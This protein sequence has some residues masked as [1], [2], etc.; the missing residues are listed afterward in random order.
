MTDAVIE[1]VG[2]EDLPTIVELYNRI[3]RPPRDQ[4]SFERRFRARWNV[5]RMLARI[6]NE[7]VGFA[8]GFELKPS[9]FFLWF[10]GVVSEARRL[11]IASQLVEAVHEFSRQNDYEIIR[12]E[13]TNQ[14]RPMLML[15]LKHEYD[16][17]GLRWDP[18]L[19]ANL[20]ILE[21]NL[22]N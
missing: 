11:G 13:C 3:F 16:V 8:L 22:T 19:E 12:L 14:H 4:E 1:L 18:D 2:P 10:C 6:R 15:T 5:M 20:I 17:V 9:V 21:K 7:P